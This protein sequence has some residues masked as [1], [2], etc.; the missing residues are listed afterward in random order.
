MSPTL[1]RAVFRLQ[2]LVGFDTITGLYP[3][4]EAVDMRVNKLRLILLRIWKTPPEQ[5]RRIRYNGD[6]TRARPA[7][8]FSPLE[9]GAGVAPRLLALDCW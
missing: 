7:P 3:S 9:S 1:F 8:A 4:R 6:V 5:R 2:E